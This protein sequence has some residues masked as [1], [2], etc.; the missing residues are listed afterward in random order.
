MSCFELLR[1]AWDGMGYTVGTGVA[2]AHEL[3]ALS[4]LTCVKL[5]LDCWY[6]LFYMHLRLQASLE[7]TLGDTVG[8]TNLVDHMGCHI[9]SESYAKV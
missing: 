7:P 1:I 9:F 6:V 8:T 3:S 2:T 4:A 5:R